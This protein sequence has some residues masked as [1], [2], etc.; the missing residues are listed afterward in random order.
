MANHIRFHQQANLDISRKAS[1]ES[2]GGWPPALQGGSL[3]GQLVGSRPCATCV[4]SSSDVGRPARVPADR[5]RQ[6]SVSRMPLSGLLCEP[7]RQ[8][9]TGIGGDNRGSQSTGRT[10]SIVGVVWLPAASRLRSVRGALRAAETSR[11]PCILAAAAAGLHLPSLAHL[12]GRRGPRSVRK[13][14]DE[15]RDDRS[16]STVRGVLHSTDRHPH[17]LRSRC[18]RKS[19]CRAPG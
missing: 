15:G 12:R 9:A 6:E 19:A 2:T 4:K 14:G 11:S 1:A 18:R 13:I 16:L 8:D 17:L 7:S 5:L 10:S 3:V